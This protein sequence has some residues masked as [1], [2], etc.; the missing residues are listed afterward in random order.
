MRN[1][2]RIDPG[3]T[4][5]RWLRRR[6]IS[7][8]RH[9]SPDD[10]AYRRSVFLEHHDV[11]LVIDI[12]A[13][14]GQYA[15]D[16]R[17]YGY[18]GEIL[19]LEPLEQAFAQLERAAS[20]DPRWSVVRTAAG[21]APGTATLK[22]AGNGVSSSLLPMS[23]RHLTAAPSSAY[24]AQERVPIDRLDSIVS[25]ALDAAEAPFLKIDAQ[26]SERS[27]LEGAPTLLGSLIGIEIELSLVP[28]YD[29]QSL[30]REQVRHI[31]DCGFR[32]AGVAS[33]FWERQSGET[34]QFDGLFVAQP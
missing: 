33:G 34:L 23:E 7:V 24:C 32:L 2:L 6:G 17:E 9:P 28:L 21:S 18:R 31:E 5:R 8:R 11:D 16:L 22:V 26:G 25:A 15:S 27:I 19:S 14:A 30:W 10:P 20:T 1:R 4:A 3:E 29:G 12:G 13:N